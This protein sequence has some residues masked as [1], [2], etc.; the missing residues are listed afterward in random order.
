MIDAVLVLVME[1]GRQ[2][3]LCRNDISPANEGDE[4]SDCRLD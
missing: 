1:R 2:A 3:G 4:W